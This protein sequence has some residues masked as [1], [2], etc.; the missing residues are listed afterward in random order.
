MKLLKITTTIAVVGALIA[1]T[2]SAASNLRGGPIHH[3]TQQ[4]QKDRHLNPSPRRRLAKCQKLV[5]YR[6]VRDYKEDKTYVG[7]HGYLGQKDGQPGDTLVLKV[8]LYDKSDRSEQKQIGVFEEVWTWSFDGDGMGSMMFTMHDDDG[9]E[10]GQL[11]AEF[12]LAGLQNP[13]TGGTLEFAGT[14]G[15]L[16]FDQAGRFSKENG[17]YNELTL[18]YDCF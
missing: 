6:D 15:Y 1:T 5:V 7:R 8:P 16:T 17:Y 14:N 12:T 13:I 3:D 10:R 18:N 11:A 4:K 2:A 9:E